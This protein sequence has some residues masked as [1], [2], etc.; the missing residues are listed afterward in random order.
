[1]GRGRRARGPANFRANDVRCGCLGES[2][3][4]RP[5]DAKKNQK[6]RRQQQD[7]RTRRGKYCEDST[8]HGRIL[9]DNLIATLA[10]ILI[11]A[12]IAPVPVPGPRFPRRRQGVLA[13]CPCNP[14]GISSVGLL[15]RTPA[16]TPT[17]EPLQALKP[18]RR[19]TWLHISPPR[20]WLKSTIKHQRTIASPTSTRS[21]PPVPVFCRNGASETTGSRIQFN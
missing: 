21:R 20:M 6:N 3:C 5:K 16:P 12:S 1:M 10:N 15:E 8:R 14:R 9:F 18:Q 19:S 11:S 2:C 13:K 4:G 7:Q 17:L